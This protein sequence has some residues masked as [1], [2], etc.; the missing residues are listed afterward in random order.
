MH[1]DENMDVWFPTGSTSRRR[2][3][4]LI[5]VLVVVAI[6]GLPAA[7]LIPAVQ[8]AREAS[9]RAQCVNNLK[10]IGLALHGYHDVHGSLPVGVPFGSNPRLTKPTLTC[11]PNL[12]DKSL[13]IQILPQMEQAALYSAINLNTWIF[14]PENGTVP[15]ASVGAYAC[16]SDPEA[17]RPRDGYP[18]DPANGQPVMQP[19]PMTYTSYAG[20]RGIA[21][22]P[23]WPDPRNNCRIDP[24]RLAQLKGCF[25]DVA[26]VSFPDITDGLSHT[27]MVA[28]KA[29]T[30][31]RDLDQF[32]PLTF[33]TVGWWVLGA[34]TNT[35]FSTDS[36]PNTFKKVTRGAEGRGVAAWVESASSLHPDGANILMADGSARFVKES[37]QSWPID[38]TS[39]Q[40]S[41]AFGTQARGFG[42]R[43]RL[44]TA[45]KSFRMPTSNCRRVAALRQSPTGAGSPVDEDAMDHGADRGRRDRVV[46]LGRTIN[47]YCRVGLRAY[48]LPRVPPGS[49]RSLTVTNRGTPPAGIGGRFDRADQKESTEMISRRFRVERAW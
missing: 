18:P 3:F 5:E 15:R 16:P 42:R 43:W 39:G 7:L 27:M 19:V 37:I 24:T 44:A 23:A 4:T 17:G 32:Q 34:E 12:I 20:S 46:R 48:G 13:L 49:I 10:Q 25:I 6:I 45:G 22:W 47:V 30:T 8:S 40:P 29:V 9:L 35:I 21:H 11:A 14:E 33:E 1:G 28:E 41:G 36:P 2:G 31:Y 38:T 26:A